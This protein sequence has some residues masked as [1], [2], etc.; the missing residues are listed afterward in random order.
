M[1][2]VVI[3]ENE[4]VELEAL[5]SLFTQWQEEINVLTA[6]EEQAAINIISQHDVDLL[7]CDLALPKNLEGLS[8]LA[9]TFPYI[10]CIALSPA[11]DATA[12]EAI[13]RGASRCLEKP[14]DAEQLLLHAGDLLKASTSGTVRG[15]PIHSFLQMLETEEKTCTLRLDTMGDTGLLYI[16][17]GVLIGAETKNFLGEEAAHIILSWQETVVQI[18]HFN[19]QRK[20]QINRPLISIIMEAFRIRN[21]REKEEAS[22]AKPHQLPLKHL[23]TQGKRIPLEM[24]SR[25]KLEF[26]QLD[27]LI[28]SVMVGML[29]DRFL[30]VTNPQP[31]A[32]LRGKLGVTERVIIRY[33]HKG[34]LWM[35]KAQL[36]N[37]VESPTP[38]FFFEYPGVIHYHE[39]REAK[40]SSII[41]PCTLH[42]PDRPELYGALSDMSLS[43][44]LCQIRHKSDAALPRMDIG[45]EVLLR[46]LLPGVKEEQMIGGI[47]RNLQADMDETRIGIEFEDLQQHLADTIGDYL[48]AI[49][50]QEEGYLA[51]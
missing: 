5:V 32:D 27:S 38:L 19:G 35:F 39:L 49:D 24:G 44:A 28:E 4:A 46:C 42:L 6:S 17:D 34:R 7:V 30:I 8:L 23:S 16:Q 9:H 2:T 31:H 22:A 50:D 15:I 25:V 18:R 1:I 45:E 51:G 29:Q 26:P 10:P 43:G 47:V 3:V 21:E 14:V 33:I 48:Y 41:I 40:R 20:R 37:T 13:K 36:L 11:R 12:E